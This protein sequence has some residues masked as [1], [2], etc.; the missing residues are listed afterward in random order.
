M[1]KFNNIEKIKKSIVSTIIISMISISA[2]TQSFSP[3]NE[4]GLM[5][6][7][8]Y[9]LGELNKTHFNDVQIAGGLFFRKNID[10]RFA[11]KIEA[12]LGYLNGDERDNKNDSISQDRYLHF[13]SPLYE[14]STQIEFNF[15]PYE[16]GNPLYSWT[17]F[18]FSGISVFQFNPMAESPNGNWVNL[19]EL[20]TEGQGTPQFPERKK[21]S[22]IQF[23][24]P[25]GGGIKFAIS[26]STTIMLEYG[27]RKTFTDY[28]DDISTTYPGKNIMQQYGDLAT[29]MSD[30]TDN[31]VMGEQRG[32][33]EN[34][35]WYSFAFVTI[36]IKLNTNSET[37]FYY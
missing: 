27:M 12:I 6:G 21:Y 10:R 7:S 22:L 25:M 24:V 33:E 17:P 2:F 8:S 29:Y 3:Y 36:S 23:S 20:G 11:Y 32:E 35:D 13:K 4:I 18:V 26:N 5:L 16:V 31:H 15:L 37:C 30:P 34:N 28:L 9:Y 1:K 19:Q 14:F